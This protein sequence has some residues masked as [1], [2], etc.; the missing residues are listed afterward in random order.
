MIIAL[1][2]LGVSIVSVFQLFSMTL[3]STKKAEDYT[4]ALIYVRSLLDEAYTVRDPSEQSSELTFREG[5]R[6]KRTAS[7]KSSS[8]DGS[9]KL[10]E[11]TASVSWPPSGSITVKGLRTIYEPEK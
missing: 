3:R 5:Y 7:V 10:Y 1:A 9:V 4:M 2:I 8:E 6:G 11:I